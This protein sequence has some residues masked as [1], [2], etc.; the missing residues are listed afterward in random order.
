MCDNFRHWVCTHSGA[1]CPVCV[2]GEWSA[3]RSLATLV[4]SVHHA[5]ARV[6]RKAKWLESSCLVQKSHLVRHLL[7]R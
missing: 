6:C 4:C 3:L 2:H 1:C 7:R 5:D